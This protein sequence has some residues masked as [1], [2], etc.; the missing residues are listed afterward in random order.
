MNFIEKFRNI[1]STFLFK[2]RSIGILIAL[3]LLA[4]W[5]LVRACSH[6]E[7]LRKRVYTIGRDSSW[8]PL[9]LF[10]KD[11]NLQAF[12]NDLIWAIAQETKLRF[13]WLATGPGSLLEG[14]NDGYYDAAISSLRQN[15][16]NR[17]KYVFSDLIFGTGP[18]L[19]VQQDSTAT[20]L[21]DME[22]KTVGIRSGSYLIFNTIKESGAHAY[23]ILI[24]TYDNVNKA[25]ESLD[26]NQIDGIIMDA[27]PAYAYTEGF[28]AGKLKVVTPPLTD[29]GLR[30]VAL[31]SAASD[32]LIKDF[33]D[34]LRKLIENGT[35]DQLIDK[36][37][38]VDPENRF[39]R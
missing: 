37:N 2:K 36:W 20:S 24:T 21:K 22:D 38:L 4:I 3:A 33:D 31:K 17:D 30:L 14:L 7:T 13:E 29:E 34:A 15:F 6:Q 28:Y 12:T 1:I 32:E 10:G 35:Y 25:L 9:Q 26:K 39:T 11:R 16:I 8:Y 19:I 27:I 23:N 18:V 5:G